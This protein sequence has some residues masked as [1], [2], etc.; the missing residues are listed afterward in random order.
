MSYN[1]LSSVNIDRLC[2]LLREN[3]SF[4]IPAAIEMMIMYTNWSTGSIQ[5]LIL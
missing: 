5:H 1:A 4:M 3:L 2:T